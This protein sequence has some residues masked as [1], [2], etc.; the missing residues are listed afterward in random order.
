MMVR[1]RPW[2]GVEPV[3][4]ITAVTSN[5][6]LRIPKDCDPIFAQLMKAC[7]RQNP[8]QRYHPLSVPMHSTRRCSR[9]T[10]RRVVAYRPTFEKVAEVLSNYY[11]KLHKLHDVSADVFEMSDQES[12]EESDGAWA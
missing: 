4:I 12:Q 3:Q 10:C 2:T 6:R 11:K 9:L 5:T 1:K 8:T 7:W